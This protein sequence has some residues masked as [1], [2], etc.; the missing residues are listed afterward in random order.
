[1][2]AV[3]AAARADSFMLVNGTRVDAAWEWSGSDAVLG[4]GDRTLILGTGGSGY[5]LYLAEAVVWDRALSA[6]EGAALA[7]TWAG[8]VGG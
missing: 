2:V 5:A 4:E 1:M 8:Y 6:A 7:A 3:I